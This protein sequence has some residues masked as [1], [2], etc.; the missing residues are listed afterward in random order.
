M[1][2]GAEKERPIFSNVYDFQVISEATLSLFMKIL[3]V[4]TFFFVTKR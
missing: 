4:V 2:L 3:L 1:L